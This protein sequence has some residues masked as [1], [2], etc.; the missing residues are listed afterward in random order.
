MNGKLLEL[1]DLVQ[2]NMSA[3]IPWAPKNSVQALLRKLGENEAW[4][5]FNTTVDE[6]ETEINKT[7]GNGDRKDIDNNDV[8]NTNVEEELVT[9]RDDA[10]ETFA[11][12]QTLSQDDL[13]RL[14]SIANK[15]RDVTESDEE[16]LLNQSGDTTTSSSA[17][18]NFTGLSEIYT[19]NDE[20]EEAKA[21]NSGKKSL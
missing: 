5:A 13:Q 11:V 1:I 15:N 3:F 10:N 12:L 2:I 9:E 14:R 18:L 20:T 17:E 8:I 7:N 6:T 19:R 4:K 16:A 21:N